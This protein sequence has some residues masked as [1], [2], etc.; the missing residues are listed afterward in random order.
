MPNVNVEISSKEDRVYN[1]TKCL[2]VLGSTGV[3]LTAID[4]EGKIFLL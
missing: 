1:I 4:G 3:D 2:E